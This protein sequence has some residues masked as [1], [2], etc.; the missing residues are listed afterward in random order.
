[1]LYDGIEQFTINPMLTEQYLVE[2][3]R[4]LPVTQQQ[5]VINFLDI[6][7]FKESSQPM[8]ALTLPTIEIHS[9]FD[10]HEAAK[11]LMQLLKS[12]DGIS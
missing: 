9:Q 2:T 10:S 6:L 5:Q 12:T 4:D 8:P 3:W 7:R 11:D 1:L